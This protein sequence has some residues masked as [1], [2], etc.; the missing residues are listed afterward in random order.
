MRIQVKTLTGNTIPLEVEPSY[1]GVEIKYMILCKEGIPISQ[2][3]I[4]TNGRSLE[5]RRNLA[6][7][8]IKDKD[9]LHLVLRMGGRPPWTIDHVK[10]ISFQ[11]GKIFQQVFPYPCP[12][13]NGIGKIACLRDGKKGCDCLICTSGKKSKCYGCITSRDDAVYQSDIPVSHVY[14]ED[15][16]IIRLFLVERRAASQSYILPEMVNEDNFIVESEDGKRVGGRFER[17]GAFNFVKWIADPRDLKSQTNYTFR[18]CPGE[19][20]SDC[21][22]GGTVRIQKEMT[23]HFETDETDTTA[24]LYVLVERIA[25]SIDMVDNKFFWIM[26]RLS[27]ELRTKIIQY[28]TNKKLTDRAIDY[29]REIS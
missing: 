1:Y 27:N 14:K 29:Y 13:C 7:Y 23:Y 3:R 6:S 16:L 19:T 18:L 17:D 9:D 5:D 8:D 15:D 10:T 20:F 28:V 21:I 22:I 26:R 25:D 12:I 24:E 2:Q 4:I 11:S